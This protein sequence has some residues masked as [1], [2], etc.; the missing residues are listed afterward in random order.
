LLKSSHETNCASNGRSGTVERPTRPF[1]RFRLGETQPPPF[2]CIH[3]AFEY[4]ALRQP[5]AVAMVNLE[6]N[7]T[8]GE[9]DRQANCLATRLRSMGVQADSQVPIL[10][11]RSI[12]MVV[13]I[14]GTIKA[15]AAYVPLDGNIVSDSTLTY[16]LDDSGSQI[17]LISANFT[18]RVTN[19][20]KIVVR[21]DNVI[22]TFPSNHCVKPKDETTINGGAYVIYTSGK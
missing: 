3:H 6:E 5:N 16:A 2:S 20:A 8:H 9:L 22:C 21:L 15:G 11:E 19:K 13:A 7:I 12:L 4:H 1:F 18:E 17:V 14:L 10:I